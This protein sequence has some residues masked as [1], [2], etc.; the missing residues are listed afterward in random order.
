MNRAELKRQAKDSLRGRWGNAV[1]I[2]LVF[3]LIVGGFSAIANFIPFA[4]NIAYMILIIPLSFGFAGQFLKFS[5]NEETGYLD[6]F[7]IGMQNFGK[8]WSITGHIILKFL[9][10]II[11]YIICAVAVGV[12][13]TVY[14]E[15]EN[16][17]YLILSILA[18]ISYLVI[19]VLVIMKAYYYELSSYVGNNYEEL[20]GKQVVEK[21]KQLMEGHRMDLFVLQL[22]FIGW[23]LL[24]ICSCG[25]GF[26]WLSPYMEV[27]K[28]KFF[29]NLINE[30]NIDNND[31][32]IKEM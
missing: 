26:L 23:A 18:V 11:G 14:D 10:Y 3:N 4:G 8:S 16:K 5:R 7:N 29:E 31:E 32:A 22:S 20:T 12:L 30:N 24:A 21:S 27:T 2:M 9:V 28:V 1:G 17:I 13:M 25:I 19:A 15:T 6:F